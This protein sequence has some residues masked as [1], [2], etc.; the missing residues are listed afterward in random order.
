[1]ENMNWYLLFKTFTLVSR[2]PILDKVCSLKPCSK[3]FN[4]L[5]TPNPKLGNPLGNVGIQF[6]AQSHRC[7][8]S[9]FEF[10]GILPIG[11]PSHAL[12]LVASPRCMT[13]VRV[14]I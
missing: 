3:F 13:K 10:E 8:E 1:M 4:P 12:A 11:F 9:V 14:M 7:Y 6:F 2:G 5:G